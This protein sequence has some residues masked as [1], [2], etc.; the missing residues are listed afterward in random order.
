MADLINPNYVDQGELRGQDQVNLDDYLAQG[1]RAKSGR[2]CGMPFF[3]GREAEINT[4]RRM[5]NA[6]ALGYKA[7]A[8]L[9]VEGPPGV[10]KSAL[11][12]RF[13]EELRNLPSIGNPPRRWLPV[14]MDGGAAMRPEDLMPAVENAIACRLAQELL[15]STGKDERESLSARL[16]AFL[17]PPKPENAIAF[18]EDVLARGVSG[19]GFSVGAKDNVPPGTLLKVASLRQRDWSDWQIMLMLD[20]AQKISG[21]VAGADAALL[22]SIHQGTTPLNLSFCAFGLPGTMNALAKGGVSRMSDDRSIALRG[23]DE[24]SSAQVIERCFARYGVVDAEPWQEAILERSANWPQ[25]LSAY[26]TKAL[27]VMRV[28]AGADEDLGAPPE[29]ALAEAIENGDRSRSRYYN[30]QIQRLIQSGASHMKYA[31]HI[32]P[33]L[34][35]A[36]GHLPEDEV[37]EALTSPPLGLNEGQA[38]AFLEAARHS[39]LLAPG[40]DA[41]LHLDIPTFAGHMLKEE[42]PALSA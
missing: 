34:R 1:D 14:F 18:A 27:A 15:E 4:F 12:C 16:L 19:F 32:I 7:D 38:Q 20:E 9:A 21:E 29:D 40:D 10:G 6:I 24:R 2:Q 3:S 22:S 23:L 35:E 41:A 28:H 13:M 31:K 17:R 26:L 39:G 36:D 33:V 5:L 37:N 42:P 25:H 30:L 11:L 8:T